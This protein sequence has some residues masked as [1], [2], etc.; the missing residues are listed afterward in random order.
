MS[1]NTTGDGLESRLVTE[2]KTS[3]NVGRL[4][5]PPVSLSLHIYIY[6]AFIFQPPQNEN[7][8]ILAHKVK[9]STNATESNSLSSWRPTACHN[10]KSSLSPCL[11]LLGERAIVDTVH[12]YADCSLRYW[13]GCVKLYIFSFYGIS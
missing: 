7:A 10:F 4:L 12:N 3:R 13:S 8:S 11:H 6:S 5:I 2:L 9:F 1:W